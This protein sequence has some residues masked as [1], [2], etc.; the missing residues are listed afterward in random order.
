MISYIYGFPIY[1]TKVSNKEIIYEEIKKNIKVDYLSKWKANCLT[2]S[3]TD[4][5][6]AFRSKIVMDEITKHMKT[7]ISKL[8]IDI[9]LNMVEC[10]TVDCRD[11]NDI[12]LNVYLKGHDQE[13][14]I[15]TANDIDEK[16]PLFSFAYFAKYD[17][18]KDAKFIF[19]NP[20][21]PTPCK[22]LEKLL[23]YKREIVMDV[24][25]GDVL[26]FPSLLP[27]RVSTHTNIEPRV[28]ISGN[29]YKN[30]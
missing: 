24:E 25:E 1:I 4:K 11:C 26:F 13:T 29:F 6:N 19:V 22:E 10:K 23:C 14:H 8:N 28:T 16:E 17:P 12:W 5:S 18:E 21:P 7:L 9:D 20:S 30:T 15:H 2:S 27:H 3:T